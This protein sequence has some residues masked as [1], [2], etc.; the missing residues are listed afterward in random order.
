MAWPMESRSLALA[1]PATIRPRLR[2]MSVIS[3]RMYCSSSRSMFFSTSSA[4]ALRRWLIFAGLSRGF[5]SQ[6]RSILPPMAVFVRS[7]TQ[8]RLPFFSLPRMVSVSSRQRLAPRSSSI[9][10]PET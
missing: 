10:S 3:R 7:S 8:R 9:N 1:V 6:L 5:S 2:S 4:T